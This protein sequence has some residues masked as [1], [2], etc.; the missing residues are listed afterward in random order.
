MTRFY[1]LSV[2][3]EDSP[4]EPLPVKVEHKAHD[5]SLP[6]IEMFL[7]GKKEDLAD[8][9]GWADDSA[10]LGAHAGTHVDAPW[11]YAPLSEGRP[12]RTIDQMPLDW[13]YHDGV[14]LDMRH[15]PQ[16]TGVTVEDLKKALKKINYTIKPWDIVMIRTDSDKLWGKPEYFSAGCGMTEESTLWLI[17]QGSRVMGID[18]WGWDRPFAAIKE[19]FDRTHD[20]GL[21][22]TA[23]KAGIKKEYCHIEKLA[24]LDK[25]PRPTGFKVACFP[26]RLTGGS[27]GWARVVAMFDD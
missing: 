18:T 6:I 24:N 4:S 5:V 14:V 19:E 11:H 16:G 23:H 9:L 26:V 3:T 2:P 13:F 20:K 12:A 27:A 22:W 8:G 17:E 10:T 21:I 25:L 7:G 15:K 1:D